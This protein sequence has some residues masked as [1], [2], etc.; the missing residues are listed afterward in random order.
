VRLPPTRHEWTHL[1]R[2]R[3]MPTQIHSGG[4]PMSVKR[5]VRDPVHRRIDAGPGRVCAPGRTGPRRPTGPCHPTGPA[6]RRTCGSSR[7]KWCQGIKIRYFVGG[8]AGDAFAS[9]FT[10]APSRAGRHRRRPSNTS[11][12]VGSPRRWCPHCAM[13]WP[14]ADGI[15][16]MGH[17]G[18]DATCPWPP[19]PTRPASHD[20]PERR[21]ASARKYGAATWA[22]T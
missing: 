2:S 14:Q 18:D 3:L 22:R 12:P 17:P 20:V 19:T 1:I 21:R 15:A 8:E 4:R 16:M 13:P 9:S 5:N 7:D 6:G 10:R 11:S